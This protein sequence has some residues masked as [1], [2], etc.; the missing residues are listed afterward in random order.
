M[1]W[2]NCLPN[3]VLRRLQLAADTGQTTG[4]LFRNHAAKHSPAALQ[5][6]LKHTSQGI[7]AHVIKARGASRYRSATISLPFH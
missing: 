2:L 4:I 3:G 6:R 7:H 1:A 5:L